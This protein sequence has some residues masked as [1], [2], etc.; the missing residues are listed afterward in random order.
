MITKWFK[1]ASLA[2]LAFVVLPSSAMADQK[3]AKTCLNTK[4]WDGYNDGWA[5]R[6]AVD[7]TL[8]QGEHRIYLVTLYA[9]NQYSLKACGDKDAVNV[10]LVLHDKDG[11]EVARDKTTDSE[12]SLSFTPTTTNTYYVALYVEALAEQ[13]KTA[14]VAMAVTYK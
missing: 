6:T 1:A 11:K 14:S 7:T 2:A 8:A 9:G 10:D 12:P 13:A 4:I 3:E 5:V